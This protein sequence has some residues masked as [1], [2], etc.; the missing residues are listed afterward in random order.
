M[1]K[2]SKKAKALAETIDRDKLHGVD[3]AIALIGHGEQQ[4]D[5]G[6]L[7]T[8]GGTRIF[9]RKGV[10]H[11]GILAHELASASHGYQR[12]KDYKSPHM[13]A[14]DYS[15]SESSRASPPMF[16]SMA[17]AVDD[18]AEEN[19]PVTARGTPGP[20]RSKYQRRADGVSAQ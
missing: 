16:A 17:P 12:Q 20:S 14:D 18:E 15:A 9:A 1:A 6:D 3:E 13:T 2:L 7:D 4:W 10:Y 19:P 8:D 11:A 5:P